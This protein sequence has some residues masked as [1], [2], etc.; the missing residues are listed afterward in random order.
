ME[1]LLFPLG[2]V[3]HGTIFK[4]IFFQFTYDTVRYIYNGCV[5]IYIFQQ[6]K[7]FCATNIIESETC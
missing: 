2:A 6:I 3:I 4:R 1:G 5:C 7:I